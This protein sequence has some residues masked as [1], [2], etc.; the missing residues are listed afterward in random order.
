[1]YRSIQ[2]A[3]QQDVPTLCIQEQS[4]SVLSSSLRSEHSPTDIYPFSQGILVS[5]ISIIVLYITQT[6]KF[7]LLYHQSQLLKSLDMVGFMLNLKKSELDLVQDIHFL[8]VCCLCLNLGRA[9]LPDSKA[10]EIVALAYK[11]SSQPLLSYK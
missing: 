10:P 3:G 6:V 8:G 2:T 5:N 11:I 1:M 4:L 7:F 9:L